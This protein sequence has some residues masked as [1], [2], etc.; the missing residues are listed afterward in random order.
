LVVFY[1]SSNRVVTIGEEGENRARE[2]R[3]TVVVVVVAAVVVVVVVVVVVIA[4]AAAAVVVVD[5]VCLKQVV[6]V[7]AS[8]SPS[9]SEVSSLRLH[10]PSVFSPTRHR[11]KDER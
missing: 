4:A 11:V 7:V 3:V 10:R 1:V 8:L 9:A 2:R 5:A 6:R